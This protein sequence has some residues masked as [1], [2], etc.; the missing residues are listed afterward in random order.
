MLPPTRPSTST[1]CSR[2]STASLAACTSFLKITV[3]EVDGPCLGGA[4]ELAVLCDIVLATPRATF[5]QPEIDLGCFP[6]VAA[7]I[8]PRLIGK[9]AAAMILGGEPVT[10]PEALRLGLVTAVVD[11][12]AAASARWTLRLTVK[13]GVALTAARRALREGSHG[14][15]DE[16]LTRTEQVYRTDVAPSPDSAEGVQAFLDKRPPRWRGR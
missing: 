13:S 6:P 9:A 5:G 15:F 11:D 3:A 4:C 2:L 12:L 7:V 10:A 16:A 1:P 14:S 8:L